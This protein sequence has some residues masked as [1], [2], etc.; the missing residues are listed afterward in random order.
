MNTDVMCGSAIA[1]A[2]G[3]APVRPGTGVLTADDAAVRHEVAPPP[4]VPARS[5]RRIHERLEPAQ[6]QWL[7]TARL[8]YGPQ[9]RILDIS[10]G[11]MLIQT[12]EEL[13]RNA[14]M[15]FELAGPES[16]LLMPSRVLRCD[17]TSVGGVTLYRGACA[18]MRP[19]PIPDLAAD[20]RLGEAVAQDIVNALE[21]LRDA[22]NVPR[23][24]IDDAAA[25]AAAMLPWQKV[26]VRYRDGRLLRGY[27]NNFHADRPQLHL[28]EHPCVGGTRMV[29]LSTLKAL[30]FVREFAGDPSYVERSDFAAA[31]LGRKV[32]VTFHDGEVLIGSTISY[33]CDGNGFFLQPADPRSNNQRVFVVLGAI[34]HVRFL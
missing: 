4:A 16:T 6:F 18:F 8:K 33:R 29:P 34:Q 25:E 26:I 1:V 11:G 12:E 14:K 2:A 7:R 19:L 9:V 3:R 5:N 31:P 13:K 27:T 24:A 20:A 23:R 10:A 17:A 28:S 22:R 21:A 30:F 15:V 32:E